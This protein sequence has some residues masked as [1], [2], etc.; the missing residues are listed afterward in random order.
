MYIKKTVIIIFF[1]FSVNILNALPQL[2][3]LTGGIGLG[4]SGDKENNLEFDVNFLY[5]TNEFDGYYENFTLFGLGITW[6]PVNYKYVLGNHYWSF[7]NFQVFWNI[8]ALIPEKEPYIFNYRDFFINGAICGPFVLMNYAPNLNWNNYLLTYGIRYNWTGVI[9]SARLYFF[10][11][12]CGFR[13]IENINHFYFNIGIDV[14]FT[15]FLAIFKTAN[16]N[17]N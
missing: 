15:S 1:V 7:F 5:I 16:R 11:I 2:G 14:I 4:F 17:N 13:N 8:F 10:N 6:I 3:I 9:E 12:E